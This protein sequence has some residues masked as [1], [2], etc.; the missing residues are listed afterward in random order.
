MAS[1]HGRWLADWRREVEDLTGWIRRH[2]RKCFWLRWHHPRQGLVMPADFV[3][4][5][6]SSGLIMDVWVLNPAELANKTW[7]RTPAEAAAWQFSPGAQTWIK[8]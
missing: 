8:R 4:L 2:M 6:E 5:A 1:M 3:P 7:P